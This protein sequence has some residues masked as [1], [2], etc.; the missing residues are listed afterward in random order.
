[1]SS[2]APVRDRRGRRPALPDDEASGSWHSVNWVAGH[3]GISRSSV[4]D[5]MRNGRL[6]WRTVGKRRRVHDSEIAR[7]LSERAS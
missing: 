4:Y 2:T 3:L 1:M 6:R 7:Y 5:L